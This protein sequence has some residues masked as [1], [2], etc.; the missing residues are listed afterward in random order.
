MGPVP[1]TI[2]Q[3]YCVVI[4]YFVKNSSVELPRLMSGM[5]FFSRSLLNAACC[6]SSAELIIFTLFSKLVTVSSNSLSS[7]TTDVMFSVPSDVGNSNWC[8]VAVVIIVYS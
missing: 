7:M 2:T 8:L 3:A 6:W 1:R 4:S 5:C